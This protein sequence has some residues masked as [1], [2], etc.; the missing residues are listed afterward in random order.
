MELATV[1]EI[2]PEFAGKL[3]EAGIPNAEALAVWEDVDALAQRAGIDAERVESF[4]D[5]ARSEME[6]IL[7]GAGVE[8]PEALA[9]AD[10]GALA[11]RT[12]LERAYLERY[13][14][15]AQDAL[16]RVVLLDD[17]AVARVHVGASTH[18]AVQLVTATA[19]DE[20]D[21]VLA[22][23]GGDAVLLKP[24]RDV[25]PVHIAGITH[26]ALP[27]YKERRTDTGVEEVRVRI[28]EIREVTDE[29]KKGLGRLFGRK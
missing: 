24:A 10:V 12:G 28:A 21:A 15:R 19:A 9:V 4:R 17:V 16:G 11:E 18:H 27:L 26:R 2:G 23:A 14:R 22:R 1:P 5:A 25:A 13:Q 6:R 20:D 8:G 29:K 3:V 7:T